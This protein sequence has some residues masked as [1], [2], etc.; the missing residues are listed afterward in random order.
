MS[1]EA[2]E[3]NFP[4]LPGV[5]LMYAKGGKVLYVG[6]AISLKKR[7]GQY[8]RRQDQRAM[9]PLLLKQV[10]SIETFVVDTEKEALLLENTLIKKHKPP[11]NVLLKDDKSFFCLKLNDK[12]KWPCLRLVR[13]KGKPPKD[14]KYFGPYAHSAS[15]K[16]T[17][18]MLRELFPLRRCSDRELIN[19][20]RPCLLHG[21]GRCVAPCVD[22]CTQDEYQS[23]VQQVEAFLKGKR[24]G[25]LKAL[26]Q[27]IESASAKM[28]YEKAAVLVKRLRAIQ[29]TLEKQNVE[30][31]GRASF[32]VFGLYRAKDR[33][34]ICRLI[35]LE[36]RL[37]GSTSTLF[38]QVIEDDE[39]VLE[40][41]LLQMYSGG[42]QKPP[43]EILLPKALKRAP[44][45]Q[46]I[47]NHMGQTK[48]VL[49][50]PQKGEKRQFLQ[51][52]MKNAE[53]ALSQKAG[54]SLSEKL[55]EQMRE[56]LGLLN[57]PERIECFDNSHISGESF[58]SAMVV[59]ITGKKSPHHYRKFTMKKSQPGDD[60]GALREVL[61]RRFS[62]MKQEKVFPD[63]ILI[64]GGKGHLS[65]AHEVMQEQEIT[66]I[67]LVAC[68]KEKSRHDKGM[69]QESIY[70]SGK[71]VLLPKDSSLLH[72][73]QRVRDEAHRYVISFHRQKRIS[74]VQKSLLDEIPGVGPTRKR[75]LLRYFGSMKAIERATEQ[76]LARVQGISAAL[77]QQIKLFLE[78]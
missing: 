57:F 49:K 54:V 12:H 30:Q 61:E 2:F 62:K 59:F 58:V 6:K 36:G 56:K 70:Y 25:V 13:M 46:Q 78:S 41:V 31:L 76:Q 34:S 73:F 75:A 43:Q 66:G 8:Q 42:S 18:E 11:F 4:D 21:M 7:L 44:I 15:A 77:A 63:L 38:E 32:D 33:L 60:Y 53:H 10:E 72:F 50:V 17:L 35:F 16:Q 74:Q 47:L 65:L 1:D 23:L 14:G 69:T 48:T 27:E 39:E 40:R 26:Q 24:E 67:D 64:D 20:T 5:Y 22:K 68:A 71:K 37:T 9:I 55:L 3:V 28:E 51:L 19:R 29:D 52:A 45:L